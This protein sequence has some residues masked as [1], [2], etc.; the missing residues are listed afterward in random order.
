MPT[1]ALLSRVKA[2]DGKGEELIAAFQPAFELAGKEPGTLH[3]VLH[4]PRDDPDLFWVSELHTDDHAFVAHSQSDAMAAATSALA[5]R[6]QHSGGQT[7]AGSQTSLQSPTWPRPARCGGPETRAR[8]FLRSGLVC[9]L[10]TADCS[11]A[12]RQ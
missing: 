9:R 6:H 7:S 3:Y 11:S 10:L 12:P 8:P 2:K 1:V 4:R 5:G